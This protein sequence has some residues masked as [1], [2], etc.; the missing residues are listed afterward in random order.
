MDMIWTRGADDSTVGSLHSLSTFSLPN[1]EMEVFFNPLF[2]VIRNALNIII[3]HTDYLTI[4]L[5][6]GFTI[7]TDP[8]NGNRV[9]E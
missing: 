1:L 9:T 6:V 4:C 8:T 2:F 5:R 7:N 3:K